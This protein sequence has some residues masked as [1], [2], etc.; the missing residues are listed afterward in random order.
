MPA[1]MPGWNSLLLRGEAERKEKGG[2][3][4]GSG[5]TDGAGRDAI[6]QEIFA[7][8]LAAAEGWAPTEIGDRLFSKTLSHIAR[9]A[10]GGGAGGEAGGG[11]PGPP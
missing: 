10:G 7:S 5:G 3:T 2:S 11:S 6:G 4:T 1:S 8:G 9:S